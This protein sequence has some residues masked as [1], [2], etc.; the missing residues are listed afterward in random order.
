MVNPVV[1]S[2][3]RKPDVNPATALEGALDLANTLLEPGLALELVKD[4]HRQLSDRVLALI[5][6]YDDP[7]V[8]QSSCEYLR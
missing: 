1:E 4:V 5:N 6:T 8:L 7:A 3:I 2:I